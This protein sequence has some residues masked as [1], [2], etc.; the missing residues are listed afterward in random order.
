MK[1][2]NL[3]HEGYSLPY[4]QSSSFWAIFHSLIG[5]AINYYVNILSNF[6]FKNCVCVL[7]RSAGY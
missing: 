4:I 2:K 7:S 3:I 1:N 6:Y 5:S